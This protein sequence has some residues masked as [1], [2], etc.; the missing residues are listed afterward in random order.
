MF[1][2]EKHFSR[3][4]RR[5]S[6]RRPWKRSLRG[7][8]SFGRRRRRSLATATSL[9]IEKKFLDTAWN[10]V[11]INASATAATCELQ[12]STG[13]TLAVSVPAQGDGES[14]RDGRRFTIKSA[15]F[16]GIVN[17]DPLSDQADANENMGYYFAMV[18]DQQANAATLN[19][20]DVYVNPGTSAA[21]ML[22]K[23]LRNL[24]FSKRFRILD[25]CFVQAA[26]QYGVTDGASTNSQSA[27]YAPAVYLSWKGEISCNCS[28]TEADVA[29]VTDNAI[30]IIAF[31]GSTARAPSVQGQCRVRFVG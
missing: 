26:P 4:R 29:S 18:L 19:S 10:G 22:P 12:P 28:S 11:S 15:F 17:S 23:P 20:E 9:G 13:C 31:A 25:S 3:K 5:S 2:E 24:A 1:S 16:N 7:A 27:M 14:Q 30:H 6:S 21:S 8:K